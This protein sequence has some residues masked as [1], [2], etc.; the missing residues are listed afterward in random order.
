LNWFSQSQIYGGRKIDFISLG[1]GNFRRQG[2]EERLKA[3]FDD[4]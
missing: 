3:I 2:L 1:E 4:F